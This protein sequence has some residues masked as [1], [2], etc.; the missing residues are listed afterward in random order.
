MY[1]AKYLYLTEMLCSADCSTRLTVFNIFGIM[2]HTK[3][4]TKGEDD[5]LRPFYTIYVS[6]FFTES[7]KIDIIYIG[8]E[9]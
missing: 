4:R 7:R 5:N 2:S 1:R 6:I 8:L 3:R 9:Y